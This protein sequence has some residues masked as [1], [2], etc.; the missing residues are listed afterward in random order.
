MMAKCVYKEKNFKPETMVL[1]E[2]I[3]GVVEHY[4]RQGYRLTLRQLYYQLV[5]RDL[6]KNDLRSYKKVGNIVSDGRLAGLIDWDALV[7]LERK[8]D[9]QPTWD[10][11]EE[12]VRACAHQFRTPK[13]EDQ[14]NWVEV[15]VEKKA[16]VSVLEPVCHSLEVPFTANKGYSSQTFMRAKALELVAKVRSGQRV[17]VLYLGDHDPSGLDMDNDIVE[18][19]KLFTGGVPI[20]FKRLALKMDQIEELHLPPN[21]AKQTD[22]RFESYSASYGDESWELDA[23]EPDMITKLITD[24]VLALRDW[25]IWKRSLS[26]EEEKK[27]WLDKMADDLEEMGM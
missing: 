7:D 16:L 3:M 19:L 6:I 18:R 25:E 23:L 26:W 11:A 13:W 8:T 22:S 20:E 21:P 10:S 9:K 4:S 24:E 15:M 2:Q 17:Y 12:I 27:R 5:A 14:P 1:M